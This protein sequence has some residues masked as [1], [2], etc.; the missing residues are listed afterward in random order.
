MGLIGHTFPRMKINSSAD[1]LLYHSLLEGNDRIIKGFKDELKVITTGLNTYVG[2]GACVI[3]GRMIENDEEAQVIVSANDSGFICI[4]I[5][6]TQ[7]NTSTGT[8]GT[9]DY[10]PINNQVRL[11]VVK[12]LVQQDLFEEGKLYTFPLA[13]FTSTGTTVNLTK[14]DH[15]QRIVES[16][17]NTNGSWTRFSD[18]MMICKRTITAGGST[19]ARGQ[20][21]STP[22]YEWTFPHKFAY[23]PHIN[24]SATT[25]ASGSWG[26]SGD[27]GVGLEKGSWRIL[28]ALNNS[29]GT[30]VEL[31]AI[32]RWK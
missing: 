16:G 11:E 5:D 30:P 28:N 26:A 21:F 22:S 18:G 17:S 12:E 31:I 23:T 24:A 1:A 4:V 8:S 19:I 25:G 20:L 6:L 7:T 2:T 14:I 10:N 9:P 27:T 29:S 3:Q 15:N 13:S 32:G